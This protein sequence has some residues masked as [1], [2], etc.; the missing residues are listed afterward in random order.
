MHPA[1]PEPEAVYWRRRIGVLVALLTVIIVI[2]K[3]VFSGADPT[4]IASSSAVPQLGEPSI[5]A[6]I[7]ANEPT[8]NPSNDS[9]DVQSLEPAVQATLQAGECSD[10]DVSVLVVADR[11][12]T[13]VGQGIHIEFTV[14]NTSGTGCTRD[15]GSGAN[16]VYIMTGTT[17]V[18]SSDYCNPSTAKNPLRLASGQKWSVSIVWDGKVVGKQCAVGKKAQSGKYRV[19]G[20]NGELIS[21]GTTFTIK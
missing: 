13:N 16:E 17:K 20:R 4:P 21:R 1:G 10:N 3:L 9:S 7:A 14:K 8:S 19:Y 15:V 6:S 11:E 18:W 2:G 5:A 12:S